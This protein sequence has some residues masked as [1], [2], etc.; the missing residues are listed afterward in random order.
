MS[1]IVVVLHLI[2]FFQ[3]CSLVHE[4]EVGVATLQAI[5]YLLVDEGLLTCVVVHLEVFSVSGQVRR[6][7]S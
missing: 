3:D 5:V 2:H 7:L 6:E 1:P 4:V